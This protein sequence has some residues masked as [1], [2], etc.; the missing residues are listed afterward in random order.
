MKTF[1]EVRSE[2]EK[3]FGIRA[4]TMDELREAMGENKKKKL[5]RNVCETISQSLQ[6]L[7]LEHFP[8]ELPSSGPKKV[9]LFTH[10]FAGWDVITA[11]LNPS[12]EGVEVIRERLNSR[13]K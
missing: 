11:L 9:L 3:S 2:V 4:I 1:R 13:R 5:G 7:G 10:S 8:A 12:D 6:S